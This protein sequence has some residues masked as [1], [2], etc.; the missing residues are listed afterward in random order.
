MSLSSG[1]IKDLLC[2]FLNP[3]DLQKLSS[4]CKLT[5]ASQDNKDECVKKSLDKYTRRV[6]MLSPNEYH[7]FTR[8][9]Y[10]CLKVRLTPRANSLV[11][12]GCFFEDV[13]Y[14]F[15]D[16]ARFDG[17]KTSFSVMLDQEFMGG[18][19]GMYMQNFE[20]ARGRLSF[21]LVVRR[22]KRWTLTKRF[23]SDFSV[24]PPGVDPVSSDED[25]P[26]P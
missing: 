22:E 4:V 10:T 13:E 17:C 18:V 12:V 16:P 20:I 19:S 26:A 25:L 2:C 15:Y 7:L 5:R 14:C 23:V 24:L 8:F 11:D 6:H 9:G 21:K 1:G 3:R